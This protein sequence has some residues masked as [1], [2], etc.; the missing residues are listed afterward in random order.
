VGQVAWRSRVRAVVLRACGPEVLV[1]GPRGRLPQGEAAGKLWYAKTPVVLAAL[2][3]ALDLVVLGL[4]G[5]ADDPQAGLRTVTVRCAL[6]EGAVLPAGARWVDRAAV[7]GLGGLVGVDGLAGL[8]GG[9]RQPWA[10]SG[11]L[12]AAQ[13]WLSQAL[14]AAGYRPVGPVRQRKVWE[15]S[16]IL[17]QPTD[18]GD[19]YI[20]ANIGAPLFVNEAAVVPELARIFPEHVPAPVAVHAGRGWLA[21]ADFGAEVGWTA[22]IEVRQDV[23][24]HFARLQIASVPHLARLSAA[25]CIDRRPPWLAAQLPAW[26][27]ADQVRHWVTAAAAARLEAAIPRLAELASDL[28]GHGLPATLAHGDMHMDNVA[29]HPGGGYLFFD[30]TDACIAHPFIDMIAIGQEDNE[31]DR[32]RLRHSYLS[33]WQTLAPRTDLSHAFA[34]AEVLSAANQAISYMTLG[35]TL[36]PAPTHPPH[37][38]FASYTTHWLT[39]LLTT[40]DHLDNTR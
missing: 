21:V 18:R 9:G 34:Q 8:D 2:G 17:R 28:D 7:A 32:A 20:K 26:F 16:C 23:V 39:T 13:E 37:P 38:L 15:L 22:P 31:Q 33:E 19:V 30:W 4:L 36:Q 11:W 29:R 27:A 1:L 12:P 35:R 24:R 5:V 10:D 6:R 40:L 14:P 3:G 25:G